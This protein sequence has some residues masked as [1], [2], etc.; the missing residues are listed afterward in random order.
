MASENKDGRVSE[1]ACVAISIVF[2]VLGLAV[3]YFVG[4]HGVRPNT[5]YQRSIEGDPRTYL[6]VE[7]QFFKTSMARNDSNQPFKRLE[8]LEEQDKQ[9]LEKNMQNLRTTLL[10]K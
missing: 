4:Y 5:A 10:E 8:L 9:E 6:V 2:G 1:N 7:S 3:G